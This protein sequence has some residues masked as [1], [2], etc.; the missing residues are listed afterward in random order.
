[1]CPYILARTNDP[2]TATGNRIAEPAEF[3]NP[4]PKS[5]RKW[6][7]DK[8]S[9]HACARTKTQLGQPRTDRAEPKPNRKRRWNDE[10]CSAL[11]R[12]TRRG[13]FVRIKTTCKGKIADTASFWG[14][15]VV[16]PQLYYRTGLFVKIFAL[17]L[18]GDKGEIRAY[19]AEC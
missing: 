15:V 8:P 18:R 3:R 17:P 13:V 10:V 19:A 1:M 9:R 16:P 11:S 6:Y 7:L 14:R 5:H 12:K 2:S 4:Q